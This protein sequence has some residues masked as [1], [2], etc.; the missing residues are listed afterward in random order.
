MPRFLMKSFLVINGPNLNMLGIREPN[1]YGTMTLEEINSHIL[2]ETEHLPV[3]IEFFQ[4]NHEGGIIDEMQAA[5]YD[6]VDG[7]VLNPAAFTHYSYAIRDAITSTDIPVVEVHLTDISGR[8]PFRQVSV[9]A[10][11]C[12]AQIKGKGWQ[13]YV[14]AIELLNENA[15]GNSFD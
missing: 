11:V 13:G 5:Y 4:S 7:I 3:E 9:M 6:G 10:D 15:A 14:E 1:V 12:L 2:A 8:E